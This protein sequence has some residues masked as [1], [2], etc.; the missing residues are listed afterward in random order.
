MII[1]LLL[2]CQLLS[3]CL[4]SIVVKWVWVENVKG[5]YVLRD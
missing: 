4:L 1:Y 5:A 2:C 3:I